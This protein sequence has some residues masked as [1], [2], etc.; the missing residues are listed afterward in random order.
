MVWCKETT[1]FVSA[2]FYFRVEPGGKPLSE[3]NKTWLR[4]PQYIFS[5]F[6]LSLNRLDTCVSPSSLVQ[7]LK[8]GN[9]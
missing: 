7:S 8:Y 5:K 1:S 3:R 9:H 6:T 2:S 4:A